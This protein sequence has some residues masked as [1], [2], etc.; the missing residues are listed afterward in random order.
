MEGIAYLTDSQWW[1][2]IACCVKSL[3]TRQ[4]M[5]IREDAFRAQAPESFMNL[6]KEELATREHIPN[7]IEAKELRREKAKQQRSR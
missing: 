3:P 7:K 5:K 2:S 4:L 6:L 1:V